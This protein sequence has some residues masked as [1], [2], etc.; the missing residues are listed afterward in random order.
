MKIIL[1]AVVACLAILQSCE[2][3]HKEEDNYKIVKLQKLNPSDTA[4]QRK[5]T[6]FI[7]QTCSSLSYH[8]SGGDYEHPDEVLIEAR[9]TAE[10]I[11]VPYVDCITSCLDCSFYGGGYEGY[12][13]ATW[14]MT[15]QDSIIYNKLKQQN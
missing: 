10:H 7:T 8:M 5:V 6:N 2:A 13:R 14:E 12:A 15:K 1:F 11:Y 4:T 3:P 9:R